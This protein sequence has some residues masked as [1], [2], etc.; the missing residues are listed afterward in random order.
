[1]LVA[2]ATLLLIVAG[3]LV[4]SNDAGLSVPD[5]PLSYGQWMPRMVGGIFYEHGHRMIATAVGFLTIILAVWLWRTD[6][7]RWLR[8]LGFATLGAVIAQG[9]LGGITVIYLLPWPV[10]VGH[11]SLAQLFFSA[12]VAIALFTGPGWL[13]EASWKTTQQPDTRPF[14]LPWLALATFGALF[15]Q[16][17]L[18]ATLRHRVIGPVPH[19]VWAVVVAGL[20]FWTAREVFNRRREAPLRKAAATL[21]GLVVLQLALG[22]GAYLA[23]LATADALQ[24]MPLMVWSTVTHVAV[25]A[26]VLAT[27][28]VLT[29]YA[30][31]LTEWRGAGEA[32]EA[33]G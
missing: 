22:T 33:T 20:S 24:P 23:R 13:R 31:R 17:V 14:P 15:A 9:I 2:A 11:A 16:L 21:A 4:T 25:G 8:R 29:L 5:W 10:S 26:L 12:T 1:M 19:V 3:A 28:G 27:A 18:G 30:F 32:S 7:R 6:E